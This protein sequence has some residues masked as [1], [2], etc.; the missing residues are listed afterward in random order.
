M[1][2]PVILF[3]KG[4]Q[5]EG[6]FEIASKYLPVITNRTLCQDELVIGRFSVLP[7]Y[8]ELEKDLQ[9]NNCSLI[10][11]HNEHCWIADFLY[12]QD[13][14]AFTP[15]SWNDDNFW[16]CQWNGPFVVKG[17][18]NSRKHQWNTHMFAQNKN[19]AIEV[20]NKLR[21]DGLIGDQ[22]I[23]Y[24]K[25]E[26][27]KTLEMDDICGIPFSNEWRFFY[28]KKTRLSYGYYWTSASN[29]AINSATMDEAGFRFADEVA[30]IASEYVTF[31]VLDIAEKKDGGWILIEMNDAQM[32]GLSMNA[33]NVMYQNLAKVLLYD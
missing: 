7:F 17:K 3:R 29:K 13:L 5:E 4:I 1:K 20:A 16:Q 32:S 30:E 15:E 9:I 23:I 21:Q 8:K 19:E 25:Y 14:K 28:Y 12:Y 24:R 18:T 27:L 31:F 6:E 2:T 33:P 26:P 22:G 11:S 10:N